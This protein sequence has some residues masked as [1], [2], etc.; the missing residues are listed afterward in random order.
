MGLFHDGGRAAADTAGR[1]IGAVGVDVDASVYV[2]RLTA[3][4]NW[5]LLGL[6]PAG[7]LI[8]LLGTAFYRIRLRGLLDAQAAIESAAKA[9]HAAEVLAG[10]RQR[11]SA[12]IEGT[13]VGIWEWDI[14]RDIQTVD[15]RWANMIGYRVQ[16]LE[17]L[18]TDKWEAM[19]HPD[20]LP[21]MLR[22]V[23]ACFADPGV[24]FVQEF[25]LRH[26]DG[27]WIWILA[28]AKILEWDGPSRPLRMAGIHLDV[29]AR[30]TVE[31]SLKE[32]ESKFRS[33]FELSPVGIALNELETG[34]FL[35]VNDAMVAPTGY[36]R[37]ELLQMTYWDITPEV[38]AGAEAE[39]IDAMRKTNDYGPYEKQYRRKDGSTYPVLL[40]GIRMKDAAGREVIW[41]IVQDISQRKAMELELANAARRDKLTG[42]ANRALFMER[43]QVPWSACAAASS[44]CSRCSSWTSTAS[45]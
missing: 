26:A 18:T 32:S 27:H 15:Q 36:S 31:L 3:A 29:S 8:A 10:E 28:H 19:V 25:R 5:A 1:Q 22:A 13:E 4:R 14:V 44:R 16:D 12:V 40:S 37:E 20:D 41:S 17:P 30:K 35:Q 2:A 42:L 7:V 39:Q 43:L 23:E 21:S 9:E 11:L 34:R 38:H 33:L 45:S 6:I 24:G